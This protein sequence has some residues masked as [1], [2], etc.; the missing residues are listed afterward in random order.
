MGTTTWVGVDNLFTTTCAKNPSGFV[1]LPD[2]TQHRI[3]EVTD[4]PKG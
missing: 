1:M 2:G 4:P 3:D